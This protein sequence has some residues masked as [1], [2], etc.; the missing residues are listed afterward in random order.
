M[1]TGAGPGRSKRMTSS[2]LM[3]SASVIAARSVQ[4][5]CCVGADA[6]AGESRRACRGR[7]VTVMVM[8]RPAAARGR[9]MAGAHEGGHPAAR[10]GERGLQVEAARRS[11]RRRRHRAG[12]PMRA[13]TRPV[14]RACVQPAR[15]RSRSRRSMRPS[16]S[17]SRELCRWM[18]AGRAARRRR[19]CREAAPRA[20]HR[21]RAGC[22]WRRRRRRG[23][24]RSRS[25]RLSMATDSA[26][27]PARRGRM[28]RSR[29]TAPWLAA[30][31]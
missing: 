3:R 9:T 31:P 18:P 25:A 5:P 15:A 8:P 27:C 7:C 19:R 11:R 20:A 24:G 13:Q 21:E 23:R 28:T 6:V 1:V 10:C 26:R 4:R 16:G 29:L 30:R 22:R 2:P 17:S 12:R 14:W